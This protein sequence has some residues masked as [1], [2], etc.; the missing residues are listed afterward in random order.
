MIMDIYLGIDTSNYKTSVAIYEPDSDSFV[1]DIRRLL[2]VKEGELGLRQS[3]ALFQHIKELPALTEKAFSAAK[4]YSLAACA[5]SIKPT[6]ADNSYMPCFLAGEGVARAIAASNNIPFYPS[7]HQ[8]GHIMAALHSADALDML[9]SGFIAVHL[10]GGTTDILNVSYDKDSIIDIKPISAS[11][12]LKAGQAIDR[13]GKMLGIAFPAGEELERLANKSDQEFNIKPY[14]K[15]GCASFSG[16]E[17]QC[18]KMLRNGESKEDIAKYCISY[19]TEAIIL[20]AE[21][22][23][24]STGRQKVLFSG[25]VTA[26]QYL[27]EKAKER[28]FCL[29][30]SPEMSG[31][32]AAG[33]AVLCYLM[34]KARNKL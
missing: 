12:D 30:G 29:F 11:L 16:L 22:A 1:A 2:S 9:E 13:V 32:N 26:N 5:A 33:L 24:K 6:N 31:D 23:I 17:N 18:E 14:F 8:A 10:S 3:E 4:D 7:N 28:L 34:H 21:S 19:V 20:M 15:D 25:G 27:R